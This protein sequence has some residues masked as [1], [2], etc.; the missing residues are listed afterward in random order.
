MAYIGKTPTV[1]PL[2]SSDVTDG[3]ITNA[4]LAQDIISGD[5][6]LAT[7]PAD[8]D[9][10]LVSDAGT[11]KR[12]DYS[13]IKGTSDFVKVASTTLSSGTASVSLTGMDSTYKH[14]K[15]VASDVSLD[16]SE[17]LYFRFIASSGDL[18][19]SSYFGAIGGSYTQS[20]DSDHDLRARN[21]NASYARVSNFDFSTNATNGASFE[22]VIANPSNSATYPLAFGLV[23]DSLSLIHI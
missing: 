16:T 3:I 15:V 13:H 12:I 6:E 20:N 22:M 10:F 17:N 5:T 9:E 14:Y 21:Y 23:G 1:V 7:A 4:K 18:T 8:T 11:L 19:G 2:T